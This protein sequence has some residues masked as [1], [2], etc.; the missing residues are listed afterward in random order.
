MSCRRAHE[1]DVEDFLLDGG[2]PHFDEFRAHFP[3]CS[4]CSDAVNGWAVLED[5]LRREFEPELALD[6]GHPTPADLAGYA[7]NPS[8]EGGTLAPE[9]RLIAAHVDRCPACQNETALL[10]SFDPSALR[11]ATGDS[12]ASAQTAPEQSGLLD[13]LREWVSSIAGA[14][15]EP[16]PV[17]WAA[18]A[19]IVVVAAIGILTLRAS[20]PTER[21]EGPLVAR[22]EVVPPKDPPALP[23]DEPSRIAH[24]EPAPVPTEPEPLPN[25]GPSESP[26]PR[27]I[28]EV[29]E[30]PVAPPPEEVRPDRPTPQLPTAEEPS[31][32]IVLLASLDALPPAYAARA[33]GRV[34]WMARFGEVRTAKPA[35]TPEILPLAPRDHVGESLDHSPRLWWR[36]DQPSDANVLITITTADA[37]DPAFEKVILAPIAAGEQL[38]DLAA[39]G[40]SLEPRIDYRWLIALELDPDRPSRNPIATG[41]LRVLPADDSRRAQ[42][43]ALPAAERG[44][45]LSAAGIWYDA[46]DFFATLA[47]SHP[48]SRA[49]AHRDALAASIRPAP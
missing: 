9:T 31:H 29:A 26:H 17:R 25:T 46:Y 12:I 37:I 33:D 36:I 27:P 39:E 40:I 48:T 34:D 35:G 45:A 22:S 44:H 23:P 13:G 15:F 8:Y 20:A 38:L 4:A 47:Q 2:A 10:R 21:Q 14:L 5:A 32:E 24:Q 7:R 19:M 42:L 41:A 30:A 28:V 3:T 1:I 18:P 16:G 49:A 11:A 43:D 6:D